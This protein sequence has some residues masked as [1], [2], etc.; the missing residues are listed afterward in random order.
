MESFGESWENAELNFRNPQVEDSSRI[1]PRSSG[2]PS[3]PPA[4]A[5]RPAAPPIPPRPYG[6]GLGSGYGNQ[7]G[8]AGGYYGA[9]AYSSFPGLGGSYGGMGMFGSGY[10]SRFGGGMGY[11]A[12]GGGDVDNR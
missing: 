4:I 9:G 11:P 5:S 12:I 2:A 7:F 3:L 1:F 8:G 6:V 10:G